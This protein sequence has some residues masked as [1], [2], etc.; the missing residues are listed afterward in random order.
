[1]DVLWDMAEKA[2]INVF[3]TSAAFITACMNSGLEPGKKYK[4][5]NLKTIGSTGSPLSPEGFRWVY[6]KVK[7]D[8]L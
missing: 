3:G 2:R 5:T 6:E 7:D 1:M 4:L 8:L